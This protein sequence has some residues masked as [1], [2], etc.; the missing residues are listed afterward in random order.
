MA[1]AD[2]FHRDA[3]AISQVL[4]GFET[5]AFAEHLQGVRVAIAFGEEAA[6]SRDG[7]DLL[8][9][10]VRLAAR[11]YPSL[12]FATVPAGEQCADELLT[13]AR[14][15][16]PN[17]EASRTG[18]PNAA[19]A[20]G[21]D[22][23]TV[24][25]PTVYAGCDGWV[26]RIGTKDPYGTSDL[27]NPFG[28]GFAACLA[29]ANLFRLLFLPDGS[30]SL[31]DDISFPPD[32][33][34]FPAL[35]A[36]TLLDPLALVGAGAVGNSAVWALARAPLMG[37]IWLIDPEAVELSN[38]QRYVL[39]ERSDEDRVKVEIAE[40]AFGSALR[41]LLHRGTWASFVEVNG[42]NWGRV[43][44]ALDSARDRRAVQG[45]L[46]R[47]IANAW[48]QVGDLGVSSHAFLGSDACLACLYLPT[49]GSRSDDEIIANGLR[50]PELQDRVRFLLGSGQ[51]T[52]REVCDV[53]ATAWGIPPGKL[54]PYVGRPIRE[55]WVEGVCGGGIIPLG[56]VGPAPRELHVP[57]AFQ[58]ALAG[59]LL[60]AEAVRDVLLAGARRR[61]LVYRLDLLRALGNP[62]PRPALKART[63][64]CICEDQDFVS[65]YRAKYAIE[66]GDLP[67]R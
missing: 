54:E 31:D 27:A 9:L 18:A 62:S 11:L 35:T 38:L 32:A 67:R 46:P 19:L 25:A 44:V 4:Q 53:I 14:N 49:E 34:S 47:W 66:S 33:A 45:S 17:I 50:I 39:C 7:R 24:D 36:T 58:S 3:V 6:T 1:L 23:P 57:L 15:I 40:S 21:A 55:L 41:P 43:L 61:T 51:G 2:F 56:D 65:A 13:L 60:A 16:N 59:V 10:S 30:G 8:D 5:D 37:Q 12:M 48:T 29:A 64:T 22:A 28:A 63:G 20:V 52:D 26:G 42:Y